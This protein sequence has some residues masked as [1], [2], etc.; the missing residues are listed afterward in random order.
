MGS[1]DDLDLI[2]LF[3]LS[4]EEA[5]GLGLTDNAVKAGR[6]AP[7][8]EPEVPPSPAAIS[9]IP[10]TASATHAEPKRASAAGG[11]EASDGGSVPD[12]APIGGLP[13]AMAFPTMRLHAFTPLEAKTA[14]HD[15]APAGVV[16]G[17]AAPP[18][19]LALPPRDAIPVMGQEDQAGEMQQAE[20]RASPIPEEPERLDAARPGRRGDRRCP[21]R[22]IAAWC[23]R[24]CP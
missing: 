24:C 1:S 11:R 10:L 3:G 4:Q 17:A 23:P 6:D 5:L 21:D 18:E 16:E 22:R 19:A 12:H 20:T 9:A 8:G 2:H 7:D 15:V 14:E 13:V